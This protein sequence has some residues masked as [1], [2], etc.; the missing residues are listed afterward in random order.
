VFFAQAAV[1]NRNLTYGD[2]GQD[3]LLLQKILNSN[4]TTQITQTGEGAPGQ[5]TTYFGNLTRRAVKKFQE[6]YRNEILVP[7]GLTEGTGVVGQMTRNKLNTL[8]TSSEYQTNSATTSSSQT[9][10]AAPKVDRVSASLLPHNAE[11]TVY[12]SGFTKKNNVNITIE[13]NNKYT[14]IVSNDGKTIKFKLHTALHDLMQGQL[15]LLQFPPAKNDKEEEEQEKLKEEFQKKLTAGYNKAAGINK[16]NDEEFSIQ[17]K[18]SVSNENG[19][20]NLIPINLS[21]FK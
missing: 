8:V 21:I 7:A 6:L 14:G 19:T 18:L 1:F 15:D 16:D 10:P 13:P 4:S 11:V 17:A 2:T 20:S 3:V 9:K 5:E 12:G